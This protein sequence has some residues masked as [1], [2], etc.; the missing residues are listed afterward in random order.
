M[1]PKKS[2]KR[3][4]KGMTLQALASSLDGNLIYVKGKGIVSLYTAEQKTGTLL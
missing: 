2:V 1:T 3:I 4:P